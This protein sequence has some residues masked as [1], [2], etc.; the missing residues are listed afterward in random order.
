MPTDNFNRADSLDLGANWATPTGATGLQI[1]SN[2]VYGESTTGFNVEYYVGTFTNNQYS[3]VVM[4]VRSA[5]GATGVGP[6]VRVSAGGNGYMVLANGGTGII[7][8]L[9]LNGGWGGQLASYGVS[10]PPLGAVIRL[11]AEG[12][13]LRVYEDGVLRISTTD[14]TYA[15]GNPGAVHSESTLSAAQLDDWEGGNLGGAAIHPP[16]WFLTI[17]RVRTRTHERRV[18]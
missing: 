17:P 15:T 16:R 4:T 14:A 3:Q 8:A 18:R 9:L 10:V 2:Q 7:L 13:A 11:E 1:V 5:G 12:T 6:T